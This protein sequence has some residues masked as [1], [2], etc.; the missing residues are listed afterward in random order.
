MNYK[1]NIKKIGD[2]L[3]LVYETAYDKGYQ[4][5]YGESY[6]QGFTDGYTDGKQ[7]EYDRFW[8]SY[9]QNGNRIA[10]AGAFK[11]WTDEIFNPKYDFILINASQMF[12]NAKIT[13]FA[14]KLKEKGLKFDTSKLSGSTAIQMFQESAVRDVPELD[15]RNCTNIN[16]LFQS[17][18]TLETVEKLILGNK[19]T[20][21]T[22]IF[23]GNVKLKHII[24]EGE[25]AVTGLTISASPLLDKESIISLINILSTTTSGLAVTL[26]LT[27]V[28]KAFET[29]ENANDGSNSTE[30]TT[31]V[32]TKQN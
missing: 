4:T 6:A 18:S 31:L 27:A 3:D 11:S 15:L 12:Q 30:W 16:Y 21:A 32:A 1:D 26:S 28:S 10:Y 2:K 5:G 25:L 7:A 13:T 9:Q 8:D 29:S 22:A 17:C 14:S 19:L 20:G 23:T 24:F